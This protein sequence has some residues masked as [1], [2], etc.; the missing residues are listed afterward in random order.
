MANSFVTALN[1]KLK[2]QRGFVLIWRLFLRASVS[3]GPGFQF[4]PKSIALVKLRGART[5]S[6]LR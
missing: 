3:A 5:D 6:G 1:F 2:K 4:L